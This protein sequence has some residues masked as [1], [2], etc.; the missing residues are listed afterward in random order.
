MALPIFVICVS[1]SIL[2]IIWTYELVIKK[3]YLGVTNKKN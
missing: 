2:N 3:G 1:L